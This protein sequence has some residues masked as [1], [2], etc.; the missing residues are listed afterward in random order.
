M[1]TYENTM[2]ALRAGMQSHT[3]PKNLLSRTFEGAEGAV[4]DFG[5]PVVQSSTNDRAVRA[6][7]TGDTVIFGICVLERSTTD[8]HFAVGDTARIMTIGPVAVVASVA[9]NAGDPVYV[10][11]T[12]SDYSNVAGVDLVQIEDARFDTSAGAGELAIVRMK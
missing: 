11:V 3:G 9:V 2:S 12:T 7:A 6:P 8:G 1:Q 4:L 10:N 5:K